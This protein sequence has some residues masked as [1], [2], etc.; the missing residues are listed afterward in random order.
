MFGIQD[1]DVMLRTSRM[2][3]L[4]HVERI[5][6]WVSEVCNLDVVAKKIRGRPKKTLDED[7][8]DDRKKLGIDPADP[9]NRS[10]WRERLRGTLVRQAQSSVEVN[11]L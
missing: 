6:G 11:S 9:Q 8:V 3:W 2:R 10:E 4:G 5:T 7:L 1:L